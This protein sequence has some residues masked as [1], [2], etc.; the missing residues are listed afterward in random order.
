MRMQWKR[1]ARGTPFIVVGVAVVGTLGLCA[2]ACLQTVQRP[3]PDLTGMDVRLTILHT[4]DIHSRI[5]PY[6]FVPSKTDQ[7]LG[8]DPTLGPYGGAARMAWAIKHEEQ[9]AQRYVHIDSGDVF[10]GAPVFNLFS[11]EAEFRALSA[12]GTE[13][14]ALGNHEFD[15]GSA[16]LSQ[17]ISRWAQFP[18]LASNYTFNEQQ[19]PVAGNLASQIAPYA[20]LDIDGL[21]VAVLGLGNTE[22]LETINEADNG[23]G[24]RPLDTAEQ[25]A[26]YVHVLR[27]QVDL[28]IIASH[29][30]LSGDEGL[31]E[32]AF[33][34]QDPNGNPDPNM[35]A[36]IDGVDLI[37]GGHLHIVTNPPVIVPHYNPDGSFHSQT[38]ICHSSA[39]AK[40]I[41][42]LDLDVQVGDPANPDPLKQRGHIQAFTYRAIPI[43]SGS[44]A[45]GGTQEDPEVARILEP[46]HLATV[47]AFNL[48]NVFAF[49]NTICPSTGVGAVCDRVNRYDP[50][51][52]DS[53]LGNLVATSMRLRKSV[54]A[55]FALTN[56]L[57]IRD[58]FYYGGLDVEQ[59]FNVFPFE[60]T[61]VTLLMSGSEVQDLL[62]FVVARSTLRGCQTQAATSGIYFDLNCRTQLAENVLLGDNC[63][64]QPDCYTSPIGPSC[65]CAP[66]DPNRAYRVA[67]N[68]YIAAGGSG[69]VV[70]KRN[71][72]QQDTGISLRDAL[73]DYLRTFPPCPSNT[74]IESVSSAAQAGLVGKRVLDVYGQVGCISEDT[75]AHD[76]R[77]QPVY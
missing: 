21:K 24:I 69:F 33:D 8:L 59:M 47:Q 68:N 52:G 13:A 66:L 29:L 77:I 28:L 35:V 4:S 1:V 14:A 10:E 53:Q 65:T 71:T 64:S 56:S 2:S 57:G 70:L 38:I 32:N 60:N 37:L 20:L 15:R 9:N 58:D 18:I 43:Q 19:F 61:I 51:G 6:D 54:N 50:T 11:G 44:Y 23:L 46:Y 12:L 22:S 41:G 16:N 63:R 7:D 39:F 62:N 67:V 17:Q 36:A 34:D 30:G 26:N 42:R 25:V 31:A 40:F 49:I 55:D 3:Q 72:S 48:T 76:G 74:R 45:Q 27:P 75:Q 73:T 5:F